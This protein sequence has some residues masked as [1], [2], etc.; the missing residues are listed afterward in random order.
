MQCKKVSYLKNSAFTL[1]FISIIF[2]LAGCF[3][4]NTSSDSS[5]INTDSKQNSTE[6]HHHKAT[7]KSVI[8]VC[9]KDTA[10]ESLDPIYFDNKLDEI[11]F[12]IFDRLVKWDQQGNIVPG[13]AEN[14]KQIDNKTIQFK[15]RKNVLFHNGETFDANDVKFS[16]ERLIDP[17]TKSPGY[18][19]LKSINKVK[20]ID[21]Y[22]INIVTSNPDYLFLRKLTLVQI[23]PET[24]FKN[25]G[26]IKFGQNPIGTGAYKFE[27]W[28]KDKSI[29]LKKN[30]NYWLKDRPII[31]TL[32]FKFIKEDDVT[33]KKQLDALFN[34]DIDLITELPGI[35]S[36][37]V[38]KYEDTKVIKMTNQA[39]VHKMLFNT[40][41]E[42]FS[43]I[44]IRK[45]VN[46]ALNRDVLIK[47][48][49]KGNGRN[50]ATN[51]TKLEFGHNPNLEPY[52]YDPVEAKYLIKNSGLKDIHIKIAVTEESE[53]IAQAIQKDLERVDIKAEYKVMTIREMAKELFNSKTDPKN[54]KWDYDLTIYTG[55]DPFMH[56]GFLYG[57]AVY[58]QGSWSKVNNKEVDKL[59]E[60]LETTLDENKQNEICQ[61]LEEISYNNYWYTPIFQVINT[62]GAT[63]NLQLKNS[64]TTFIDLT[65][66]Y[67]SK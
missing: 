9:Q 12:H 23:L 8:R 5:V 22:T 62:Y 53:L 37:K 55:V 48:L 30:H 56:V 3:N 18:H 65:E 10:P 61:K 26:A 19:L 27:K 43:N 33:R 50:I 38:Q 24:Y 49:A 67:Y 47:V 39:K 25:S 11:T 6:S 32:V 14:W 31:E 1:L 57:M 64:A 51:S 13:L 63:K 46:L 66:A 2:I 42:P 29:I 21:P 35:Y 41:R 17:K 52:T 7:D 16:I 4:N 36:L 15:L 34:G 54:N 45:A 60:Q 44:D 28:D 58:S 20:I 40:L 59:Y